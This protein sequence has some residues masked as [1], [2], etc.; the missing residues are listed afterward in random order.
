MIK[1]I[2]HRKKIRKRRLATRQDRILTLANAISISRILL[3]IPLL[4]TLENGKLLF[5][6][7][8][9]ILIVLS[10]YLDGYVARKADEITNF[11]KLIDPI[12]DKICM[13]V[14]LVYLL[15]E[16]G[17]IFFIFFTLLTIRDSL[18]IIIGAYLIDKKG[19]VFQSIWTG[20]WFVGISALMM[21]FYL[22]GYPQ[23]GIYFYIISMILFFISSYQYFDKYFTM[24]K[25][26]QH[27]EE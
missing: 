15:F 25:A 10:D 6:F 14:V 24:I 3:A 17:T 18:L 5:G 23:I 27:N 13:M 4:W 26:I 21:L 11:G 2:H 19:D 12:A 8:I 20:K 9:I 16:Y 22:L 7:G 1:F